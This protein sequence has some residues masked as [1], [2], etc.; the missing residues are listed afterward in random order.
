MSAYHIMCGSF[1]KILHT[2]N[3]THPIST[4]VRE[5]ARRITCE[6]FKEGVAAS[7]IAGFGSTPQ[8]NLFSTS[9]RV[10]LQKYRK[11]LK[12]SMR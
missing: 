2:S 6:N 5:S 11:R 12:R 3:P 7:I 9:L 1:L 10:I 4:A 8:V